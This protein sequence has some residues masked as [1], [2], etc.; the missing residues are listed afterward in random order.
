MSKI[1]YSDYYLPSN[2]VSAKDIL[3]D[4]KNFLAEYS[5][6]NIMEAANKYVKEYELSEITVEKDGDIIEIFSAMLSKMLKKIEIVPE[7]IKNIFYTS[8]THY[9]YNNYVSVPYYLQEKYKLTNAS[10]MI[11]NQHCASTLQA[12]RIADSLS[13]S[14]KG[15]CSLIISPCFYER[16]EDRYAGGISLFGDGASIML[17]GDDDCDEGFKIIDSFSVSDGHAS[18]YCYDKINNFENNKY[19]N[20]KIRLIAFDSISKVVGKAV[21]KYETWFHNSK[22][23]I[24]QSVGGKHIEKYFKNAENIY[25]NFYG[26]HMKDVD[27][28]RNLREVMDLTKFE[29]G[30]KISLIALGG[31]LKSTSFTSVFCQYE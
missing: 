14:E 25:Q 26:G 11:L 27:T 5:S 13:K 18:L 30:D 15:A 8:F 12:M 19:D 23:I 10:V 17:I 20:F 28:T 24:G 6:S 2:T 22:F 7:E 29:K 21:K 9:D 3:L 1:L 16:S 31:D 4:S